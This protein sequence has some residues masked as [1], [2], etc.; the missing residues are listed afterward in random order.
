MTQSVSFLRAAELDL[1]DAFGWYELRSEG[2]G[3]DF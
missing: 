1:E 2:W 3:S